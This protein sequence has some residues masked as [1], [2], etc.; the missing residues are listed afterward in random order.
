MLL[1]KVATLHVHYIISRFHSS[2]N[3]L[4]AQLKGSQSIWLR[5]QKANKTN[6]NVL[7]TICFA[8]QDALELLGNI[9]IQ[10]E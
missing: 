9:L 10:P 5:D 8:T 1:A 3:A 7:I 6:E 2:R 4:H